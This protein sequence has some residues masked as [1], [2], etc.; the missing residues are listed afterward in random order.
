[1]KDTHTV[2]TGQNKNVIF[3]LQ[4]KI[5]YIIPYHIITTIKHNYR[6]DDNDRGL[7]LLL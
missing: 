6:N 3:I 1:M 7:S 4:L 2:P 5:P